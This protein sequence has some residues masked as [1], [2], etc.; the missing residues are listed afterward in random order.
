MHL[1]RWA[2]SAAANWPTLVTHLVRWASFAATVAIVGALFLPWVR[3]DGVD[4]P[5]NAAEL[6]A[7]AIIPMA[8]Y[9]VAVSPLQ[10]ALLMGGPALI[11]F[12]ALVAMVRYSNREIALVPTVGILAVSI[13]IIYSTPDLAPDKPYFGLLLTIALSAVLLVHQALVWSRA[14]LHRNSRFPAAYRALSIATGHGD[15]PPA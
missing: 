8:G 1:R 13:A 6:M 3:L 4:L 14:K 11:A 2:G 15:V 10:A 5:S 9:L 12:F 7:V